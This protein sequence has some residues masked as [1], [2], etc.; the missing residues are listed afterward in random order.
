[1]KFYRRKVYIFAL[2]AII[3]INF[4]LK[5]MFEFK[6]PGPSLLLEKSFDKFFE[7]EKSRNRTVL[8]YTN[9]WKNKY[10]HIGFETVG[11]DHPQMKMCSKKNCIFTH[12]KQYLS[13]F[14]EYD[15]L[16]FHSGGS[17]KIKGKYWKIPEHRKPNQIYIVAVQ[18]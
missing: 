16:I 10:W 5:S 11:S 17:W 4:S 18:E 9:F 14:S 7:T 15:A 12:N 1:M 6:T 3:L 13:N 2:V 8:F